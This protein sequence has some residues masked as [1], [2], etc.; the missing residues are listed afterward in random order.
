MDPLLVTILGTIVGTV[1]AIEARAWLPHFSAWVLRKTLEG[2]PRKLDETLRKRWAKEIEADL[3]SY[4]D[5][6][7]GGLIFAMRVRAKGARDLAAELALQQA[8][9]SSS[10]TADETA[11]EEAEAPPVSP[12]LEINFNASWVAL[13]RLLGGLLTEIAR[14]TPSVRERQLAELRVSFAHPAVRKAL[15][16]IGPPNLKTEDGFRVALLL[17]ELRKEVEEWDNQE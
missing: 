5:R 9:D 7:V 10:E 4:Q 14:N 12:T 8:L 17:Q 2:L 3:A 11:E 6:P 16:R 1:L 15:Y 13:E